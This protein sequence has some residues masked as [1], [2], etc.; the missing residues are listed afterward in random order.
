MP[1]IY[2]IT[3]KING[4]MYIGQ[5][6]TSINRRFFEHKYNAKTR[7]DKFPLYCAIRK[8]GEEN[9]VIEKIEECDNDRLDEREIFWIAYFDTFKNGY[10]STLG[11]SGMKKAD[12]NLIRKLWD[13]GYGMKAIGRKTKY[14]QQTIR[15]AL[16]DYEP[17]ING[18]EKRYNELKD[19]RSWSWKSVNQYSADGQYIAT[20]LSITDA[21]NATNTYKST[22]MR[23]CQGKSQY[24]NGYQWRY[25]DD[26]D[27]VGKVFI[28]EGR[29]IYQY[30]SDRNLL[31]IYDGIMDAHKKTQY[32]RGSIARV[33]KSGTLYKGCYWKYE[34]KDKAI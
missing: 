17:Y 20:Y 27:D 34:G 11:G 6:T 7:T 10:N 5:T 28:K 3:N 18:K 2:K 8:Y 23:V 22:I 4:K 9:F 1:Y 26:C 13:D 29:Q 15:R 25:I 30:D 14:A 32:N 16:E 31:A 33:C 19:N 12:Y 21:Q 24:A